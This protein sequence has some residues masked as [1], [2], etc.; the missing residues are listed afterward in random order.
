VSAAKPTIPAYPARHASSEKN[1]VVESTGER[2][3]RTG[4]PGKRNARTR[5]EQRNTLPKIPGCGLR[6]YPGYDASFVAGQDPP[7]AA[8]TAYAAK[9][10]FI[11]L[12]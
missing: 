10:F 7:Y 4:S 12:M 1:D 3:Y 8:A 2:R 9:P 6:P 5:G 11:A